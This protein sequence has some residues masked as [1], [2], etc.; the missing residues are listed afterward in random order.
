LPI[1]KCNGDYIGTNSW[2][3]KEGHGAQIFDEFLLFSFKLI[4]LIVR[5]LLRMILGKARRDKLYIQKG[6][7]FIDFLYGSLK[8][9]GIDYI[10]IL[11]FDVPKYGYKVH[12]PLNKEDFTLM[13]SNEDEIIRYFNPKQG[14][15]V[16]DVGAHI[17]K[18]TII[19]SKRI[20]ANGK[21]IAIEAHPVNYE[22][23]NRNIK[24]N[25]LTNVTTLNYAVYSKET[26]LKLFLPDEELGYTGHHTIMF[27]YLSSK[28][29][30]KDKESEKFIQVNANTLDNLLQK[31]GMP[32]EVNWIKIDVEGAELEVLKGAT[33][34]LSKSNDITLLIEIHYFHDD[35]HHYKEIVDFLKY[36]NF[37]IELEK[38]YENGRQERHMIVRKINS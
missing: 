32:Q 24:L 36:Y 18:Y 6:I 7:N 30:L 12:C 26:K 20:G 19:A 17:G 38:I 37:K 29:S 8:L 9:L 27:N 28:F 21:V 33:N 3:L 13:S 34:V 11:K 4:Y 15:I 35:N 5:V 16:I 2:L 22:M 14:D 10:I 1:S 25:G 23:L 31:N